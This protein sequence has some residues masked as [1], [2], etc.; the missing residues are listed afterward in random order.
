M[1][2]TVPS[3]C[4]AL[5]DEVRQRRRDLFADYDN[6]PQKLLEAI[7]RLQ[8]EHPEK[9]IDPRLSKAREQERVGRPG[10]V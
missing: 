9:V 10:V 1:S 6:E 3:Y 8:A 2:D 4:D 7:R 5:I